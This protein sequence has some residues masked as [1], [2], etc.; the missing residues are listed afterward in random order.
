VRYETCEAI[1]VPRDHLRQLYRGGSATV[2]HSSV[3]SSGKRRIVLPIS[4]VGI[5]KKERMLRAE[6][7]QLE[8]PTLVSPGDSR[9]AT[10]TILG[11]R[12]SHPAYLPV[13]W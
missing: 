9:W 11:R 6:L 8:R 2:L 4:L 12:F 5:A 10:R 3:T 1:D 7:F 13:A